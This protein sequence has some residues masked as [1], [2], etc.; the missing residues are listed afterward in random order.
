M[1]KVRLYTPAKAENAGR[2]L[3]QTPD[4]SGS[5]NG[6]QFFTND[7]GSSQYDYV[8]VF[9]GHDAYIKQ[10]TPKSQ[11]LF[12]AGEPPSIKQYSEDYLS[13]FGAIICSAPDI[14][15]PTKRL[16]QQGHPWFCGCKFQE[17]G[18]P[19]VIKAYDDYMADTH[20]EKTKLL[21][22]VCSD[23]CSKAGHRKRYEFVKHLKEAFGDEMDLY[24]TGHNPIADKSD[25]LRSYK[26]H[27]AI[28]NS[29]FPHYWTEK[30]ADS[31]LEGAYPFYAGCPNLNDYFEQE[32]YTLIDLNNPI[33]SIKII[34]KTIDDDT[35]EKSRAVLLRSKQRVLNEH[36]IFNIIVEHFKD[37][38][39]TTNTRNS[40]F[41][42]Y[43]HKWFR[44][45]LRFRLKFMFQH[46]LL[47]IA[48]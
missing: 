13:Q 31:Y 23:K 33:E 35:Y 10:K 40:S 47:H 22:V 34:R 44:K 42:A 15:H 20:I 17:S 18:E 2:I 28:E 30:L 39:I 16:Y 7:D 6:F 46:L 19:L 12:I 41:K 14:Q 9:G 48:R 37:L 38:P 43:P 32:A 4:F 5:W 36:N 3:R 45:G 24:G 26:Y 29:S 1:K 27:I 21:S 8:V 25:A 11:T